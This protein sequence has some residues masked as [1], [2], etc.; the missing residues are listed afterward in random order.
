MVNREQLNKLGQ[1]IGLTAFLQTESA[2]GI[3]GKALIGNAF[4]ALIGAV[5]LDQG[6]KITQRFIESRIINNHLDIEMLESLE[7]NFK[8]KLIEWAQKEKK[9]IVFETVPDALSENNKLITIQI[10]LDGITLKVAKDFSKK[11]AEQT[12]AEQVCKTLGL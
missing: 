10:I 7:T 9:N 12:A 11:R 6:Y 2:H 8:S 3:P 4:E 5:Y 1:K